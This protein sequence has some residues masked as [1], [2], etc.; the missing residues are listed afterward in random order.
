MSAIYNLDVIELARR[1][2]ERELSASEVVDAHIARIEHVNPTINAVVTTAFERARDEA[3]ARDAAL[4]RGDGVG[5]LF[6]VPFTIKD[7]HATE[8]IRSTS[9]LFARRDHVPD[10]DAYAV[11]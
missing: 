2:R 4:A 3:K 1:I 11:A 7:C 8:G 9:G 5:P 10:H 6:G